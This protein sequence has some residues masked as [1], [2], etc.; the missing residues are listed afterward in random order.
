LPS[1]LHRVVARFA[2][3]AIK[4][5]KRRAKEPSKCDRSFMRERVIIEKIGDGK[6][7]SFTVSILPKA[8]R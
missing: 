5:Y 4:K 6:I 7:A 1:P 8:G 2:L 3:R